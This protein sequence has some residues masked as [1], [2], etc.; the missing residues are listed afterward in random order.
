MKSVLL[1][2]GQLRKTLAAVRSL[3]SKGVTVHVAEKTR[4]NIAGFSKYC[5]RNLACPDPAADPG[6]YADWLAETMARLGIDVL[7]PMDDASLGAVLANADRFGDLALAAL[8]PGDSYEIAADKGQA[9]ALAMEAGVPVPR[10]LFPGRLE[11]VAGMGEQLEGPIV[12]KPRRSSGSRG[13]RVAEHPQLLQQYRHIHESYPFPLLQQFI[14]PGERFDVCLLYD[15]GGELKASFVQK[16]LRHF[17]LE[18]GPSTMQ[19]SVHRPDLVAMA[20][21]I[22]ERLP[23]RGVVELEF[24]VDPRDGVPKFMEINARFWNS[25]YAA[26]LSGVDFPWLLYQMALGNRIERVTEYAAGVR[27]RSLLPGDLLHYVS[28]PNR[29]SISPGFWQGAP[30]GGKDDIVSLRD[31]LPTLGFMLAC[32][33]YAADPRAWKL[34]FQR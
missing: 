6:R 14:P 25:L 10:T 21:S 20:L 1:T 30:A 23:W 22:M 5:G 8:P 15:Q 24:M 11:D 26:M 17:P 28:N 32:L 33:K 4:F 9:T 31:P 3:G 7:F 12:I 18:R 27:C 19:E 29:A 34:V 16:E 2:D 13:I